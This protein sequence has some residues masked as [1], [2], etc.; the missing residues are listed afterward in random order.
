M[1]TDAQIYARSTTLVQYPFADRGAN[2]SSIKG[3][4][5]ILQFAH[6]HE[7]Y[8]P[9]QISFDPFVQTIIVLNN[10]LLNH[11]TTQSKIIHKI[12]DA[13]DQQFADLMQQSRPSHAITVV[14]PKSFASQGNRAR[15]CSSNIKYKYINMT[16]AI[17]MNWAP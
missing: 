14:L 3:N 15:S 17:A 8:I 11:S 5:V 9:N 6:S 12:R 2:T 7:I 1:E 13:C 4:K 16:I 10:A